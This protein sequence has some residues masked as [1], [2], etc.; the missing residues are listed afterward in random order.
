MMALL[1]P[2]P[3][4]RP[5]LASIF[6]LGILAPILTFAQLPSIELH[7]VHPPVLVAG[8]TTEVSLSGAHL[9]R[10]TGL[11]FSIPNLKVEPIL[12][13]PSEFRTHRD[14]NGTRFS[15]T[16]PAD[17]PVG[18]TEVRAVGLLGVSPSRSIRIVKSSE[19]VVADAVGAA[20]H[21]ISTAPSLAKEAHGYGTTDGKQIDWWKIDLKKGERVL[22]HCHAERI[23]SQ[24][25]ATLK[26][27]NE[28]GR[29]LESSR[30]S[31]GRDPMIDFTA[32]KDGSYWVGVH[33]FLYLGGQNFSYLVQV[34]QRPWID[35]VFPPAGQQG[36]ALN[37]TL[38][39]R[40][41]PGS[42]PTKLVAADGKTLESLAVSIPIPANP[43]KPAFQWAP[44][45]ESLLTS[46]PYSHANSHPIKVGISP[47]P[48]QASKE[49][50]T[51]ESVSLPCEI[52]AR[53][54]EDGDS[55]SFRFSASKGKTYYLEV[56]GHRIS[57]R[58]DPYLVVEKI[59]KDEKGVETFSPVRESDDQNGYGGVTFP[60]RSMDPSVSFFADND[61]EYRATVINQFAK[62]GPEKTYRL[63]IREAR[64][65]FNLIAVSER[66]FIEQRQAFPAAPLLRKGGTFPLRILV[67]RQDGFK[68]PITL[69]ASGL[70]NGVSFP[71]VTIR[72][73]ETTVRA[74]FSATP[75]APDWSGA[76]SLTATGKQGESEIKHPI[77]IGTLVT[78]AN[79]YNTS[80]VRNRLEIDLPLAVRPVEKIPARIETGGQLKFTATI[81]EKLE[82]PI[83]V[84]N[85][86]ATKGN[87]V[88]TPVG[89]RGMA[90]PPNLTLNDKTNDGKLTINFT[91]QKN[92]F[93]PE[94]GT[95]NFVLKA[96]GVS[97]Y[98]KDPQSVTRA[99]EDQTKTDALIKQYTDAAAK[100][101]G[102]VESSK[103]EAE[104][105]QKQLTT[106]SPESK[107]ELEKRLEEVKA[108]AAATQAEFDKAET[109]R[110]AAEKE[111]TAAAKRV[112]DATKKAAAKDLKFA[113]WSLPLTVEVKEAPKKPEKK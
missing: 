7:S 104:A 33:D 30:D 13:P 16:V 22:V 45:A 88:I 105:V 50:K 46:F 80:R 111:K 110:A 48:V 27:V 2:R 82:I 54:D 4:R 61:G 24:A 43:P 98:Q 49:S 77:R 72:D 96:T 60:D 107:P 64:P 106:A 29:E 17:A 41:L 10:L 28:K 69:T 40:L 52:G 99:K 79:D 113:V 95:W 9:E 57:G 20:H 11:Q 84:T 67:Y 92:A 44:P 53:F 74:I 8:T 94:A 14:Q 1:A 89:L 25:D 5:L 65:D 102:A 87:L 12:Q 62:G 97:P 78:G 68:G 100:A 23:D 66:S 103:K 75:E 109:K 37:A 90:K 63:A 3:E 112:A 34:S 21:K 32:P 35:S 76:V 15:V 85:R 42:Q 91:P 58:T 6:G 36:Q 59:S 56:I 93:A 26:L 86:N 47:F 19:T 51:A 81:G 71:A 38:L 18:F 31:I 83:Q 39:G 70:P 73:K 55:D 101:K 108:K